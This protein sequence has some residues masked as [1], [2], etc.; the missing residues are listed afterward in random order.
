MLGLKN[1]NKDF[2]ADV[3]NKSFHFFN[4]LSDIYIIAG[5]TDKTKH[6][7]LFNLLLNQ[8]ELSVA[9][10]KRLWSLDL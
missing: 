7:T 2:R 1:R 5:I 6:L 8:I 9:R 10:K 4:S 3:F